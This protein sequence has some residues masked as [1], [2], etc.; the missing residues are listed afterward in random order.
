MPDLTSRP[1]AVAVAALAG[2]V[3]IAALTVALVRGGP[4]TPESPTTPGQAEGPVSVGGAERDDDTDRQPDDLE[5]FTRVDQPAEDRVAEGR[6]QVVVG[7]P[8]ETA[9]VALGTLSSD[10]PAALG[11]LQVADGATVTAADPDPAV[12]YALVEVPSSVDTTLAALLDPLLASGTELDGAASRTE[13][14]ADLVVRTGPETGVGIAVE[15]LDDGRV[16]LL[17]QVVP[18]TGQG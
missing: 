18:L 10:V 1:R 2:A 17:V 11:E 8:Q 9:T 14:G 4:D 5:T 16:E 6:E 12:G 15:E 3:L 13:H 7:T